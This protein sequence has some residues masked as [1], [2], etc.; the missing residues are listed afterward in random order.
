MESTLVQSLETFAIYCGIGLLIGLVLIL[1]YVLCMHIKYKI[2]L[3]SFLLYHI[4]GKIEDYG[5]TITFVIAA[6][7]AFTCDGSYSMY[8]GT[9]TLILAVLLIPRD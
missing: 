7:F 1:I 4:R 3:D 9:V 8:V 2:P 6:V 5:M